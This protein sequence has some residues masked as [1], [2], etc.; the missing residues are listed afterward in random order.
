MGVVRLAELLGGLSLACDLADGFAPEKVLRTAILA[1]AIGKRHGLSRADLHDAYYVTIF[2]Y[3]GCTGFAHEEAHVYGAG[4][5]IAVRRTMALA[6]GAQPLFTIARVAR[7]IGRSGPIAASVKAV[8]RILGDG[9][10]VGRHA[11]AQCETSIRLAKLAGLGERVQNALK[12]VCERWDGKGDPAKIAEESLDLVTRVFHAADVLDLITMESGPEAALREVEKRAGGLLDPAIAKTI[13]KD[14]RAILAAAATPRPFEDFL[15]AEPQPHTVADDARIDDVALA[16]AHMADLKS[17]FTLG[18]S[19]AVA[20][21]AERV[22]EATGASEDERRVVKRAGLLHDLGRVAVANG[23]WDK[24]GRLSVAEWERVRLHA[25]YTERILWQAPA[26]RPVA[27]IASAAHERLDGRGYHRALPASLATVGGRVLAAADVYVAL[28]ELRPHR[29]AMTLA[30]ARKTLLEEASS[31]RLDAAI[32]RTLLDVETGN[33]P[34]RGAWPKGL[35]DREVEVLR[36]V[37]RGRTNKEVA[38]AL[39]LSPKTV[40][41]HVAHVYDKIG[42]ES[43]AAAA[44]FATEAGLLT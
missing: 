1:M 3:L 24:R 17:A 14:G 35:S 12:H 43:R 32:V 30:E 6:D 26:L 37:A 44:M 2:R 7:G 11:R 36:L 29:A 41:H 22:V 27:A 21:V 8:A 39:G 20:A 25:Y 28:R 4:D 16:F 34:R 31:G 5:D 19:S 15:D 38:V 40:Q 33:A 23:V 18:H 42:V 9:V 13:A 10:A